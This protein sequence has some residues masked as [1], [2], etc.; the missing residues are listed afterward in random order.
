VDKLVSSIASHATGLDYSRNLRAQS[1]ST[2][3]AREDAAKRV[4]AAVANGAP[5]KEI[6]AL[7]I[8]A[9]SIR[10]SEEEL[11]ADE[12]LINAREDLKARL[13][14][15]IAD[16]EEEFKAKAFL[17]TPDSWP[18]EQRIDAARQ[19]DA[20]GYLDSQIQNRLAESRLPTRRELQ[21]K[22][23]PSRYAG[24]EVKRLPPVVGFQPTEAMKAEVAAIHANAARAAAE[25]SAQR[26]ANP[27][28]YA[29]NLENNSMNET[30]VAT[31]PAKDLDDK[32]EYI[33]HLI[34]SGESEK[35]SFSAG[36]G[37]QTTT[38]IHKFLYWLQ[39]RATDLENGGTYLPAMFNNPSA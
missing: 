19:I 16:P 38:S 29:D 21:E 4:Q 12:Q 7:V 18:D 35:Y 27:G 11:V 13:R 36:N 20:A 39:Q 10:Y 34:E 33:T 17:V 28:L 32:I 26:Q 30:N 9:G 5:T 24:I 3:Q 14:A 31:I 6:E 8:Q 25:L 15:G 23:D 2:F 37:D 22:R 1:G